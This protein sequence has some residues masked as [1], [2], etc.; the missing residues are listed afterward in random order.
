MEAE[1]RDKWRRFARGMVP[2]ALAWLGQA[3]A[4]LPT[5]ALITSWYVPERFAA[6]DAGIPFLP[7]FVF[8]YLGAFVQWIWCYIHLALEDSDL[9]Y[10]I[11]AAHLLAVAVCI[12]CFFALPYTIERPAIEG[13]GI[14]PWLMNLVYAVDPPNRIFPSLHCLA[15]YFCT[16]RALG[17]AKVGTAGKAWSVVF[18]VGVF[19]STFFVKQHYVVD[20]LVGILLAELALQVAKRTGFD[21][22]FRRFCWRIQDRLFPGA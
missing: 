1:T 18:T 15:S 16:R 2:V 6:M 20:A 7:I 14:L 11:C 17:T 12:V 13:T 10:R 8:F 5:R 3:L 19:L 9:T 21:A 4:F 22:A